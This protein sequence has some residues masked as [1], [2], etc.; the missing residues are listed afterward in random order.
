[1]NQ[2]IVIFNK[3]NIIVMGVVMMKSLKILQYTF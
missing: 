2:M 1:M 3:N